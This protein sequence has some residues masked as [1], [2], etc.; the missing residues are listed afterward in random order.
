MSAH[1]ARNYIF[2]LKQR[3]EVNPYAVAFVLTEMK[4]RGPLFRLCE[5]FVSFVLC[6]FGKTP[7]LTIGHC[8]VSYPYWRRLFHSNFAVFRAAFSDVANYYVCCA[9][10]EENPAAN[11][12]EM[13]VRYNGK[14]SDLYVES[15][16]INLA[17]VMKYLD[18]PLS[19][20]PDRSRLTRHA[21]TRSNL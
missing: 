9:Y 5:L 4:F 13:I 10:L 12:D 16:F 6:S 17:A 19:I 3:G 20:E 1:Y 2:R 18:I 14:P 8:Q 15:Y 21:H 11:I 7:T